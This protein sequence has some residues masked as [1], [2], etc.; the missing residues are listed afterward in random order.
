MSEEQVKKMKA[1]WDSLDD[2]TRA[3]LIERGKPMSENSFLY[4]MMTDP[5][6]RR[7]TGRRVEVDKD[8]R[9]GE[10][11]VELPDERYIFIPSE[12][13]DDPEAVE[14]YLIGAVRYM[15]E[16]GEMCNCSR[17]K[18]A[19]V[20][21]DDLP[22]A[23][24]RKW[25]KELHGD[26]AKPAAIRY[27]TWPKNAALDEARELVVEQVRETLSGQSS[28]C[29]IGP[30]IKSLAQLERLEELPH[31]EFC[32]GGSEYSKKAKEE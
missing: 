9:R 8:I 30:L 14:Q 25:H 4:N 15:L 24:R 28:D 21:N 29:D 16:H 27:P 7:V 18:L 26:M 1:Y 19:T 6:F 10:Y 22:P 31:R 5:E 11:V 13:N 32:E 12:L 20:K 2:E 17:L 23:Y 3:K